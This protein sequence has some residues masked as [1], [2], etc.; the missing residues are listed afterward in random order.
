MEMIWNLVDLT[1]II[2]QVC[3]HHQMTWVTIHCLAFYRDPKILVSHVGVASLNLYFHMS[4]IGV[5][6]SGL[7][8]SVHYLPTTEDI[9]LCL[10]QVY[11][12][13]Q[14]SFVSS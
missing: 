14:I 13:N 10:E 11:P 8:Q 5:S 12:I 2:C 9:L 1:K 3:F 4:S 7:L 6:S